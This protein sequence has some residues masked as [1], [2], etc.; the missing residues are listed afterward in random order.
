M[1]KH[2]KHDFIETVPHLSSVAFAEVARQ[3]NQ[4]EDLYIAA[5]YIEAL[6]AS[7]V[8]YQERMESVTLYSKNTEPT[9]LFSP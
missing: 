4:I 5:T 9:V 8:I 1:E 7:E 3:P 6:A 2:G